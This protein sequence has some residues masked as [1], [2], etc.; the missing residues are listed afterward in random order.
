MGDK[1]FQTMSSGN[2][3]D[4]F[5]RIIG[6]LVFLVGVCLLVFVFNRAFLLFG[7]KPADALGLAFTGDPKRDPSLTLVG[8]QFG[9]LL[10]RV[11]FLFL[12][13]I[14]GSFVSQKGINLY[15]HAIQGT[16]IHP[17]IKPT[18]VESE[19]VK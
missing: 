10:F 7:A 13:A 14:S 2:R 5:G 19:P 6:M 9:W 11:V 12:M 16:P 3:S 1:E 18:V 17:A 15:F 4:L 8:A